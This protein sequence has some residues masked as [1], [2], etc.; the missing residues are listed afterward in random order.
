MDSVFRWAFCSV[1]GNPGLKPWVSLDFGSFLAVLERDGTDGVVGA[2]YAGPAA[3]VVV[4]ATHY[5]G[6][7]GGRHSAVVVKEEVAVVHLDVFGR[8]DHV[9]GVGVERDRRC[10][11][12]V[13]ELSG[14][15][16]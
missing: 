16:G 5:L 14:R 9:L 15:T 7:G 11:S 4:D 2:S 12:R 6:C 3:S 8:E 1:L 10:Q 13:G